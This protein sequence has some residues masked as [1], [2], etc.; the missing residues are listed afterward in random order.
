M[1]QV[2]FPKKKQQSHRVCETLHN[3][4]VSPSLSLSPLTDGESVTRDSS[5]FAVDTVGEDM[6]EMYC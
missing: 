5:L 4:Q 1:L 2:Y 6:A 3:H